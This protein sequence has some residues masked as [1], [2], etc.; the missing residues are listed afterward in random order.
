[1]DSS[2]E[3]ERGRRLYEARAWLDAYES[4]SEADGA[5]PLGAEDLELLAT[6]AYMLDRGEDFATALEREIGRAH[7]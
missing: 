7:V 6:S 5:N 4:L 3:L 1:M 2:A